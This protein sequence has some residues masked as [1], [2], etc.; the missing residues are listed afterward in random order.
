[1]AA[2]EVLIEMTVVAPVVSHN[3]VRD[4]R[5][6]AGSPG[7]GSLKIFTFWSK[8]LQCFGLFVADAQ[9]NRR[10]GIVVRLALR[11]IADDRVQFANARQLAS[12]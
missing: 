12:R 4:S 7:S 2:I 10:K 1:M 9:C 8:L 5:I 11:A 3:L 6:A